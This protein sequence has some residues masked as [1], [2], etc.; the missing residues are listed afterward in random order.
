M[1]ILQF[2]KQALGN[3]E[4][5]LQREMLSTNRAGGY[6]NTTIVCCN[7]RK[8]HGLMVCPVDDLGGEDYML[9][10]SLDETVI[11]HEQEFNLAIHRFPGIYEPRGHKYIVDFSY[12]PTPTIIYRVGGVLLKK[13]MLWVHTAEQL[14]IRYTLLEARSATKLR[15]RPF[16]AFRSRHGLSHANME[17]DGKSYPIPGGV[18]SRLYVRFPWLHLQ[19]NTHA[20]FVSAPDWYHNFE[21]IEEE[22]RGYPFREDLLTTGYFEMDIAAGESVIFSG[23]T[24]EAR[25]DE[26]AQVFEDE[27]ARR[28]VK[29]EFLPALYHSARQFLIIKENHTS[30][31]AGYPWYNARSR[32]TFMALAGVTLTQPNVMTDEC[33]EI[34]DYHVENRLHN[35]IFGTHFAADT[36]LW[37][38]YA[39]Q[40][41]QSYIQGGKGEIWA[42]YGT[43]MKEIL[44]AYRDGVGNDRT[45]NEADWYDDERERYIHM[46]E[47]ALIWA[48]M[49]GR[50]LTWMNTMNDGWPVTQRPGFT[51]EVNALW[52]NAVCYAL[53]LAAQCGD[54]AFVREWV[55]MPERIK[56][57][58]RATFWLEQNPQQPYLADY[59]YHNGEKNA[60]IRPNMLLACSLPYSPLNEYEQQKVFTVAEAY[61]LTPRGLRTLSPNSPLYQGTCRGNEYCRNMARHQGTVFPWLLEHYVRTGFRLYGKGYITH[62]KELLDGF[63]EDVLNYGIGSVPEAYDGD[64]P[65]E[66][67][68]AISYAPS[69]AALLQVQRMVR[70][71]GESRG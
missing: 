59:V 19:T 57:N 56:D 45:E 31:T 66:A 37:F 23:S 12:T 47:N 67:C 32:E 55:E 46:A 63:E 58:F 54:D 61:L 40:Q 35:G 68:G 18:K 3:L 64:A 65:H 21:Y 11:Q 20:K 53:E 13:E 34:L 15:L 70:E 43:A 5:S 30:L 33:V 49:P 36:Q 29:T 24:T 14:L 38:F 50:A 39:L 16:L 25:P 8:Y 9:L 62:A 1:A 4:Y 17:A 22:R 42:R 60:D 51:V 69:V 44:Y 71:W 41:L 7:T 6:M 28:T 10:S 27:I 2:N 52:Y 48:E 26:L